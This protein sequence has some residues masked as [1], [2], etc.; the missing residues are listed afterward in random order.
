[1]PSRYIPLALVLIV[2][3]TSVYALRPIP[4]GPAAILLKQR[5]EL[6]LSDAQA[7]RLRKIDGEFVA[8]VRPIHQRVEAA[9]IRARQLR[10][11]DRSHTPRERV[12]LDEDYATMRLDT[13]RIATIRAAARRDAMMVL[14]PSQR[15][16]ADELT[17]DRPR[18]RETR[19]TPRPWRKH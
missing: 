16:R 17:G 10:R 5:S 3:T 18:K 8:R 12:Q 2:L 6:R 19:K 1:M 15:A 13:E 7:R 4:P 14:T 9:R 11:D